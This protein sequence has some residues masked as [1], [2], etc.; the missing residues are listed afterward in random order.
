MTLQLLETIEADFR[1]LFEA[2]GVSRIQFYQQRNAVQEQR[3]ELAAL[4]EERSLIFGAVSGRINANNR[5]LANLE[6]ELVRLKEDLSYRIIKAPIDGKVFDL[7]VSPSSLVATDQV[8]LKLVP[9]GRLVANV[10]ITNRDIGFVKVGLPVTVGVDSFPAGE[11]GYIKG[12]LESIG[13]DALPPDQANPYYRVPATLTLNQQTVEAGGQNLNLQSGM[14]VSANIRLRS[15]PVINL[16][17]DMFTKQ[18]E[19]VKNFR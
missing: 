18:L 7:R 3:T 16:V 4:R 11:F 12:S 13:S 19:G 10:N 9:E 8:V 1:P 5:D 15:R 2:G 14:S 6:S 17:T